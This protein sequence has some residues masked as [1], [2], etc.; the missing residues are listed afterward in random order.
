MGPRSVREYVASLHPRYRIASR[1]EK[2]RVLTEF[3]RVTGRHRKSAVRLLR[4]APR[5]APPRSGRPRGYGPE[6]I[7]LLRAVWEAS[8]YLCGKRLAPFLP[9][10]VEALERHRVLR[11]PSA[12]RPVLLRVSAPTIDRLLRP[13]RRNHPR[14]RA[15]TGPGHPALAAQ[16]PIRTFG[17]W[18][19]VRPGSLQADLVAH[20]GESPE[21]FFL[22]SLVAVDVATGWTE[23]QAVWGKGYARVG[24]AVHLVRQ[25]LPMPLCALHTDNG[26][27]FLNHLLVPWC[28]RERIHVTRGR[29]WRKNDQAYAEQKNWAIVRRLIGYDRYTT[30]A[31]LTQLNA[32]YSLLRLYGNFFQPLR[33][34]T[35]KVRHGARVT[36]R[37]DRAQTPYQRLLASGVLTPDQRHALDTLYRSLNP[38]AL[39]TQIQETLR[40]VW[41]L[42]DRPRPSE[43]KTPGGAHHINGAMNPSPTEA[44]RAISRRA[45]KISIPT[46]RSKETLLRRISG[47][48]AGAPGRGKDNNSR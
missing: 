22:T 40:R 19:A 35:T 43:A 18:Q 24:T 27:E 7:T 15:T 21:G 48:A 8:D 38:L 17:D 11:V 34:L 2:G 14:G 12:L 30:H 26:G 28:R 42:A 29:P 5:A 33:K 31:A 25:R 23:C 47:S 32:L 13:Y 10:L 41:Q 16:V 37:Y 1:L 3:C 6:V 44:R 20:C 9:T 36:K 39:R 46:R 4:Q 45:D